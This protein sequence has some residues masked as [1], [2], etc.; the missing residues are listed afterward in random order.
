M[1]VSA[2]RRT[3]IPAF[4]MDW[5][6]NRLQERSVLIR[7]PMNFHQ[8]SQVDLSPDVVDCIVFWSKNPA[9]LLDYQEVLKPYPYYVQFTINPYG[10]EIESMLPP[11]RE[12]LETFRRLSTA[13][14][15]A[16][17]VWRYSPLLLNDKYTEDYHL[18]AFTSMAKSLQGY[19][20]R[21]NLSF[22]E[23][24]QKI[25][26]NMQR[27]HIGEIKEQQKNRLARQLQQI[28]AGYQIELRACG[29]IDLTAA[30]I[31]AAKCIDDELITQITDKTF[32]LKKDKNQD[33]DCYCVSSID[34]GAYNTCLNG[35]LYCYANQT[36]IKTTQYK[37]SCYDP[38]SP[39][40]CSSLQPQ[41]IIKK[42]IVRAEG[43][44]QL[45]LPL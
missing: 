45:R 8:V 15:P 21:C 16:R 11:G 27:H 10:T 17:A 39:L 38:A 18:E 2:S 29:N 6:Q 42:R 24:Y 26:D 12:L 35:C 33:K 34:V 40:L 20:F 22:I 23:I 41:D 1:I 28:A 3:D 7:N 43:S 25:S 32:D 37:S 9:P 44:G 4:Y 19:T 13:L 36:N 31:P 14:G 5:F 30:E